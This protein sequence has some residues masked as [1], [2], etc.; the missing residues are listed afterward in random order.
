MGFRSIDARPATSVNAAVTTGHAGQPRSGDLTPP[1]VGGGQHHDSHVGLIVA[2]GG[3]V[4]AAGVLGCTLM[5]GGD[6]SN[7]NA[8]PSLPAAIVQPSNEPISTPL[9]ST[10]PI[11]IESQS[12]APT[13]VVTPEPTATAVAPTPVVETPAPVVTPEP[14]ATPSAE[15]V[16]QTSVLKDALSD[17][18]F[19]KTS[20]AKI[21][22]SANALWAKYGTEI[23]QMT[24]PEPFADRKYDKSSFNKILSNLVAEINNSMNPGNK[25][26]DLYRGD[27]ADNYIIVYDHLSNIIA[28]AAASGNSDLVTKGVEL[29]QESVDYGA[30]TLYPTDPEK[31][32]RLLIKNLVSYGLK[33]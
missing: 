28:Q 31:G 13:T 19:E 10:G 26:L 14:T 15:P 23:S 4:I 25:N 3:A 1:T 12:P 5:R 2:G 20:Y 16:T 24:F 7:P 9:K 29:L 30:L 27:E 32:I 8:S 6:G 33:V 18:N 21:K 11:V 17:T 22:E